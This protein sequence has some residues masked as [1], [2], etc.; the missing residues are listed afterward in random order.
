MNNANRLIVSEKQGQLLKLIGRTGFYVD[1]DEP[2]FKISKYTLNSCINKGLIMKAPNHLIFTKILKT[3]RLTEVGKEFIKFKFLIHPYRTKLNHIEHDYLLNK[4]YLSLSNKEKD[5]WMTETELGVR[6]VN[7]SVI[8]GMYTNLNNEK[9]GVEIITS[10]YS[11]E[12]I[13]LKTQFLERFCDKRILIDTS[14]L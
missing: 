6:Y 3:Y 9:V 11:E 14:K 12:D 8:D 1:K 4:V 7:T 10:N 13:R 2:S 5:T